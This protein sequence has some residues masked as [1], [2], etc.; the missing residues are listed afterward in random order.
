MLVLA[1][2]ARH[3]LHQ[4]LGIPH[5]DLLQAQARFHFFA[6]QPGRH[7]VGVLLHADRAA[8]LHAHA[9]A[10][11]RLQP[12]GRQGPQV[13]HLLRELRRPA[14]IPLRLHAT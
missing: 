6:T 9:H 8:P 13:S 7:R 12:V 14:R 10:L 11:Q 1:T 5:L 3:P 4:L 2:Q